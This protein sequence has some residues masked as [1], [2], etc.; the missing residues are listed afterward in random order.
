[1]QD[2]KQD[3]FNSKDESSFQTTL[4]SFRKERNIKSETAINSQY[5]Q[6]DDMK[7]AQ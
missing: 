3:G 6:K 7:W 5:Y 1:M 4:E 2:K